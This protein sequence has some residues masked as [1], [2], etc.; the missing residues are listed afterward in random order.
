MRKL[1]MIMLS[2]LLL[3]TFAF[4]DY[5]DQEEF[6]AKYYDN[7][8]VLRFKY[9]QGEAFVQRSYDEGFEE[10]TVNLPIFEKDRVGTT[11]G[12]VEVYLGRLNYLRLDYDTEVEFDRIPELRKTNVTF[13]VR[14]GGI[15]LDIENIDHERDIEVQT[16]DC[17]IFLLDKGVYRINVSEGGQTEVFVYEGIAE[18]AGENYSRNVRENQKIVMASGNVRERPFY[19]YESGTDDFDRWNMERNSAVGYARYSTSRYLDRGYEDYEYELSRSGRW[20]YHTT[21]REYIWIPYN[22]GT[23]WYPYYHGRWLWTPYY[24]YF[25]CSYDPWGYFTHHY[26]RWHWDSFYGWHWWPG[27][28]WSPA[29]V[30]W[31]GDS[32]YYGWCPLSRWNRPVIVLNKR[33]IRNYNHRRGIPIHSRGTIVI[34]KN[35]LGAAHIN[36][37][38]INKNL[39]KNKTIAARGA[40]PKIK[41]RMEKVNVLNARGMPVAYKKSGFLSSGKY[42]MVK[43]AAG[44]SNLKKE[45][46]YKYSGTG[47]KTPGKNAFKYSKTVRKVTAKDFAKVTEEKPFKSPT[48]RYKSKS[49]SRSTSSTGKS[50]SKAVSKSK[51]KSKYSSKSAKSSSKSKSSSGRSTPSKGYKSK[52]SSSSKKEKK[53]EPSYFSSGSSSSSYRSSS[54]RYSSTSSSP[55]KSSSTYKSYQ[56]S[57]SK[58]KSYSSSYNSKSYQSYKPSSKSKYKSSYSSSPST[59]YKSSYSKPSYK[60]SYKSSSSSRS[61][62][63]PKSYSYSSPSRSYSKSSSRSYRSSSSS[64]SSRSSRSYSRS[65]SSRSSSSRSSSSRSSSSRSSKKK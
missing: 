54:N 59:S 29:W 28:R 53:R 37:V 65:S 14:K 34:K 10:A 57:P 23:D 13:M 18:V 63:K 47:S 4:S 21:Y 25:W 24:G 26:G 15:F 8:K 39:L 49:P 27:Y 61:Y 48:Y 43:S 2:V 16:P 40:A 6:Q 33:W 32:Y 19:F 22:I 35:H 11:D 55:Y 17:G 58:K 64:S 45:A 42:K 38:A 12:R 36:K 31:F 62:S 41:P 5:P 1:L 46:A 30:Y 60:S 52:S 9:T 44:A 56:E 51:S 3:N 50:P 7:A 20:I